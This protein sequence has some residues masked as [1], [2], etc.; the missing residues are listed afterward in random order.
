[1]IDTKRIYPEYPWVV[2]AEMTER[3]EKIFPNADIA[4]LYHD[5]FQAVGVPPHI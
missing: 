3:M 4:A 2:G 5:G 1:L